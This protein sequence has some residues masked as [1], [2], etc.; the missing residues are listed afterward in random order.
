MTLSTEQQVREG[1]RLALQE[2]LRRNLKTKDDFQAFG[3]ILKE[4]A[5]RYDAEKQDFRTD[6]QARLREAHEVILRAHTGHILV[7]PKPKW[8]IDKPPSPEK[9][10]LL[11]RNRVQADHEARLVAIRQDEVDQCKVL[12]RDIRQ[13]DDRTAQVQD[14]NQ[15]RAKEAFNLTNQISRHERGL[16]LRSGPSRS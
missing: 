12:R 2:S 14:R 16:P 7:H 4:G 15:G 8:A 10:D 6:Y 11:A 13:R 1:Y 5:E 9:V 3:K